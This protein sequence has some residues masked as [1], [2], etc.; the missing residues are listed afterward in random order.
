VDNNLTRKV[1]ASDAVTIAGSKGLIAG[2]V[3][4]GL[5]LLL[6]ETLPAMHLIGAAA[7]VGFLGYGISLVLFVLA[8]RQLGSARTSAYFS[9][10]PFF[11]AALALLLQGDAVTWQL[12]VA[13]SLMAIGV[14]LHISER[15]AHQH[16]HEHLEHSH[17]HSHDEHHQHAHDSWDGHEPHSHTH[18]HAPLIHSH[19]HF[20]DVHHRHPH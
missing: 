9:V 5:A 8:L 15:H 10:A 6:G 13:G 3:N 1:S 16:A 17:S 11:G 12:M 4:L 20:P 2:A 18:V 19:A 7:A 14:W